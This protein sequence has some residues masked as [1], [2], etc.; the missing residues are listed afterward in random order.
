V[1]VRHDSFDAALPPPPQ[2]VAD[3]DD[4]G[5]SLT[6][7]SRERAAQEHWRAQRV[8]ELFGHQR[9]ANA[10]RL[11]FQSERRDVAE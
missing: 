8:E 9:R 2:A 5:A 1:A 10:F 6:L 4:R 11:V 3:D 7:F